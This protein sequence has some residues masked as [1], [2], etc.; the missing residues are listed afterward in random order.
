MPAPEGNA[1]HQATVSRMFNNLDY[2]G[3]F[4]YGRTEVVQVNGEKKQV[5]RPREEW[6]L[7][8][9][10]QIWSHETR[11]MILEALKKNTRN[12]GRKS[13][14]YVLKGKIKCGR[15]G[16][17]C[18][19]GITSKT[20]SGIYKYY[21]CSNKRRKTYINGVKIITCEGK[22]WRVDIVDEVF[23]KWFKNEV[24]LPLKQFEKY[25]LNTNLSYE[26]TS[27]KS[28]N[29][30][31]QLKR[32]SSEQ[33]KYILLFGK[34]KISEKQYDDFTRPIVRQISYLENELV[35]LKQIEA[36]MDSSLDIHNLILNFTRAFRELLETKLNTSEKRI[37]IDYFIDE[38]ILTDNNE[39]KV[40]FK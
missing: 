6:I 36:A 35:K 8:K 7:I 22:N 17:T 29:V 5:P 18:G 28:E 20:K 15:C 10:P 3:D 23:W 16:G 26:S 11:D 37:L 24:P 34:N 2:T 1:W 4:Y 38:V 14:D 9:I 13:K 21:S 30:R 32:L 19:S 33:D 31:N 25:L 27:L 40:I 39:L 12:F